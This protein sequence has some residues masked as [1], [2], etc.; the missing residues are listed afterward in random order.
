MQGL[1]SR[2]RTDIVLGLH[3]ALSLAA[4][5]EK[6]KLVFFGQLCRLERFCFYY[7][8]VYL[9]MD[10]PISGLFLCCINKI[11]T[12]AWKTIQHMTI[13]LVDTL[14]N[15]VLIQRF[16]TTI[17]KNGMLERLH[18]SLSYTENYSLSSLQI[19]CGITLNVI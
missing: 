19:Q 17:Q 2:S 9:R 10:L 7:V 1:R 18:D 6:K 12:I 15:I 5:I 16:V 4:D 11:F 14:G 3:C 8:L 13:F